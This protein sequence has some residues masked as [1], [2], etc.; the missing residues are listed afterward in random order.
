MVKPRWISCPI[1]DN[2][3]HIQWSQCHNLC[4]PPSSLISYSS[5]KWSCQINFR[6]HFI[7]W[8]IRKDQGKMIICGV[9][10]SYFCP[11][12]NTC[13]CIQL[14]T[15]SFTNLQNLPGNIPD[16]TTFPALFFPAIQLGS[17]KY[18]KFP[19][20]TL[21]ATNCSYVIPNLEQHLQHLASV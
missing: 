12:K 20:V 7:F 9:S 8:T 19:T 11:K 18:Q 5:C 3:Q 6:F 2:I 15:I 13:S 14:G 4:F 17:I 10:N 1:S 21:P 16:S